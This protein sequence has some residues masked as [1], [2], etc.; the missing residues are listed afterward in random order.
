MSIL[1]YVPAEPEPEEKDRKGIKEMSTEIQIPDMVQEVEE[2]LAT[3]GAGEVFFHSAGK[4]ISSG[5]SDS[6]GSYLVSRWNTGNQAGKGGS[7]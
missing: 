1:K 7:P 4:G 5:A 2:M 3:G 6:A